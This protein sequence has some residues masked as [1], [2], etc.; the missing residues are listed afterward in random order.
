M[1]GQFR[2]KISEIG[3]EY[4]I[5]SLVKEIISSAFK[6]AGKGKDEIIQVLGREIGLA[7]AA[8]LK[9]PMQRLLDDKS[10]Q[11]TIKLVSRDDKNQTSKQGTDKKTKKKKTGNN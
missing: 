5:D 6:N 2:K 9:E 8:V 1:V 11:I 7:W 3:E 4:G 10:L